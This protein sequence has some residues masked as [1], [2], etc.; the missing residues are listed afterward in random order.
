[1]YETSHG[2][3]HSR[4]TRQHILLAC[5]KSLST[6]HSASNPS[7]ARERCAVD[8]A[9]DICRQTPGPRQPTPEHA[10]PMRNAGQMPMFPLALLQT[11]PTARGA[12]SKVTCR[13]FEVQNHCTIATDM[14]ECV[15]HA[16]VNAGVRPTIGRVNQTASEVQHPC[17]PFLWQWPFNP[18]IKC[19]VTF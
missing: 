16:I 7:R 11:P 1:M 19:A 8:R 2:R 14:V 5:F 4:N 18:T 9:C 10:P 15:S 12:L 3:W 6:V 17:A 13:V